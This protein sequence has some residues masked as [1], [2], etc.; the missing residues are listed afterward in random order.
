MPLALGPTVVS[1]AAAQTV[2]GA[3]S[4]T[5]EVTFTFS[6]AVNGFDVDDVVIPNSAGY[7]SDFD[8]G[9]GGVVWTAV[10]HADPGFEGLTTLSVTDGYK[11]SNYED[12]H[13]GGA[14]DATVDTVAP[15]AIVALAADS[16][17][18]ASPTSTVTFTLSEA[19]ADFEASDV[20]VSG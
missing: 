12:G 20:T 3:T 8:S 18:I 4:N 1:I 16:F 15:T 11:N 17:N 6:E 5:T 13:A 2:L 14:L 7:L 19:S 10:F 9:D